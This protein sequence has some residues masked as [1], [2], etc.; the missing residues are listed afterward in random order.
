MTA[1][2]LAAC[3][4]A[5]TYGQCQQAVIAA[6][7]PAARIETCGA[8]PFPGTTDVERLAAWFVALPE[9]CR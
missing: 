4:Q 1:L 7:S 6:L 5:P 9:G 2:L 3:L 8:A